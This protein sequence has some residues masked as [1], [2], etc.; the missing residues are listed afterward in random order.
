MRILFVCTGNICRSPFAEVVARAE[1]LEAESAGLEAYGGAEPTGDAIAVA[2]ELGYDLTSHRARG[3]SQVTEGPDVVVG[4]TA[5]HV[6]ALGGS[7][8]LLG[9]ADLEDPI[10][11]GRDTYRRVYAQIERDVRRLKEELA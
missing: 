4:M 9:E 8:R 6:S 3:L 1:G 5:A 11:C 7:A 10:G 2:R